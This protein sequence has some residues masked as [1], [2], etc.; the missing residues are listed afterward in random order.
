MVSIDA[1]QLIYPVFFNVQNEIF[2]ISDL[3]RIENNLSTHLERLN[4]LLLFLTHHSKKIGIDPRV[5]YLNI[6]CILDYCKI[7]EE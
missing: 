7:N 2:F 6:V 5:A 1:A 3:F 4:R